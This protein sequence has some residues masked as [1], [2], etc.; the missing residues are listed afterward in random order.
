MERDLFKASVIE[1]RDKGE[2][3]FQITGPDE[4]RLKS[5]SF[6]TRKIAN[7]ECVKALKILGELAKRANSR[8]VSTKIIKDA[9]Q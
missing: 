5:I 2:Y 7:E 1:N 8:I 6:A 4:K 3:Y 9:I